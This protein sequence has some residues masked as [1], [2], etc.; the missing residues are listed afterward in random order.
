MEDMKTLT[1]HQKENREKW[2]LSLGSQDLDTIDNLTASTWEAATQAERERVRA[3]FEK[4]KLHGKDD[5][6]ERYND[7]ISIIFA[8]LDSESS[9]TGV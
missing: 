8:A 2:R 3:V 5:L 1:D 4:L 6:S 7:T 9:G